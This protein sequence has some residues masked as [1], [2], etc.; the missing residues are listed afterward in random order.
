MAA[1]FESWEGDQRL[2]AYQQL[3]TKADENDALLLSLLGH[4]KGSPLSLTNLRRSL[5]SDEEYYS[6]AFLKKRMQITTCL[7]LYGP[8]YGKQSTEIITTAR[9]ALEQSGS[10]T[11]T[12]L[13]TSF[14]TNHGETLFHGLAGVIG[15]LGDQQPV[16][17][18][19]RLI[20]EV[21]GQSTSLVHLC[22]ASARSRGPDL[23][24]PLLRLIQRSF[25]PKWPFC[26]QMEDRGSVLK[27][28][29]RCE[30][31]ISTWLDSLRAAGVDLV[32]Y[33][34]EERQRRLNEFGIRREFG[35]EPSCHDENGHN[36][37]GYVR[38]IKF[39]FGECPS[40]WKFWW[41][42]M[43]DKFAGDFWHMIEEQAISSLKV[44]GAWVDDDFE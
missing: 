17:E 36:W 38:L 22:Q 18:W 25:D 43:T 2:L 31:T 30:R 21:V 11:K 26:C 34:Q 28:I 16:E 20:T 6:E 4:W 10:W 39:D 19:L 29:Q 41:S 13:D 37:W 5:W 15:L 40:Q 9:F 44:P 12:P 32:K 42:E 24:T 23:E 7:V 27:R 1:G 35:L 14:S 33:G 3:I 8:V